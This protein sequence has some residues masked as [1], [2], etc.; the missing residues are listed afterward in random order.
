[1]KQVIFNVGG[2]LSTYTEFDD[3]KLLIDIGKSSDFNPIMEFLLPLYKKRN[4]DKRNVNSVEK[5]SIDQL[6][7]S[8]LHKDHLS[9]I[10]DF[11]D[12]FYPE[13][14]TC[15]N[16]NL[17]MPDRHSVNWDLVGSEN[18]EF[19]ITLR[20]ML[21][22]RT[23]P[24]RTTSDQNEFIY[25]IPPQDVED[26][27]EL[28]SE[29]YCNNISI[30][31]FLFVNNYRIFLPGDLQKLGME[32]IISLNHLLRNK[33]KGGV[34][35]LVAPHHGLKSSFSTILFD[36][37]KDNK[38]NALNIISEKP[39]NPDEARDVDSRYS[40]SDYCFGNNNLKGGNGIEKCYQVKTSRGHIFID[41]SYKNQPHFE[42]I[43]DI[44]E[45]I[46]KF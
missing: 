36:N 30:A 32:K 29:S 25:Y 5:Y 20:N 22:G 16:D 18:E 24:L 14:L 15:P 17:G 43:T 3:K 28:N 10:K 1:M 19:M 31:V 40:S 21:I 7:I 8:H 6:L 23:P 42:I 34:D 4:S 46:D 38:T 39:N 11:D 9:C 33:L 37:M 26:N 35:V 13:L 44:N 27:K 12:N 41:Y 45:L 2:A